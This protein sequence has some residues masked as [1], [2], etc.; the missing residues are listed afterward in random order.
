MVDLNKDLVVEPEVEEAGGVLRMQPLNPVPKSPVQVGTKVGVAVEHPDDPYEQEEKSWGD[1]LFDAY[2]HLDYARQLK[3]LSG[4]MQIRRRVPYIYRQGYYENGQW[5]DKEGRKLPPPPEEFIEGVHESLPVEVG[6]FLLGDYLGDP[7]KVMSEIATGD[8][9]QI[10][11]N[12]QGMLN[13]AATSIFWVGPAGRKTFEAGKWAL[14]KAIEKGMAP[15][16]FIYRKAMQLIPDVLKPSHILEGVWERIIVPPFK[17]RFIPTTEGMK[18][19]AEIMQPA[20]ERLEKVPLPGGKG[21][22]ASPFRNA[23]AQKALVT[24]L[25]EDIGREIES[26]PPKLRFEAFK[27]LR[28]LPAAPEGEK[29]V[30]MMHEG[31]KKVGT[32]KTFRDSY[33]DALRKQLQKPR[34]LSTEDSKLLDMPNVEKVLNIIDDQMQGKQDVKVI[35]KALKEV[36]EDPV[37]PTDLRALAM[38]L[39]NLPYSTVEAVGAASRKAAKSFILAGLKRSG[40]VKAAIPEGENKADWMLSRIP[41]IEGSWVPKDVELELRA[42]RDVPKIA[43]RSWG[44]YFMTPWKVSK[45]I[46]SPATHIRNTVSNVILNDIGGLPFYRVDYYK[47]A[48]KELMHDGKYWRQW[49][50][51]TG[52]GG[53]FSLNELQQLQGGLKYGANMID[54]ALAWFDKKTAVPKEMYNAEEQLAKVA[55]FMWNIER[56][57]MTPQEAALDAM[58]WTFNYAEVTRFTANVRGS[59]APFYTWTSKVLPLMAE[60]AVKHPWRLAKWWLFYQAM[61]EASLSS[62]KISDSEFDYIHKILPAYMQD[63]QFL[64]MPWRDDDGRLQF[65]NL[66]YMIP[67]FGDWAD[68]TTDPVGNFMGTPLIQIAG[69]LALNKTYSGAPIWLEEDFPSTKLMKA[70]GFI[71]RQ[72][73][74]NSIIMPGSLNWNKM[75]DSMQGRPGSLTWEQILANE[76]GFKIVPID[77][78]LAAKRKQV[79]DQIHR[80]E[81]GAEMKRELRRAR[82]ASEAKEI[83]QRYNR[84]RLKLERE[85]FD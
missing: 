68:I 65:L 82:N 39:Y 9:Y 40:V 17:Q 83:V 16:R 44:R 12:I 42:I 75:W 26:M 25:G 33:W 50:K 29:V 1:R 53:T 32:R 58:K 43:A 52:S 63:G 59:V 73:V 57:H 41:G 48:V 30:K 45:V 60:Q 78:A 19:V 70:F 76:A 77:P 24:K 74:P 61:Q 34:I 38:D 14:L 49:Q 7:G 20:I 8:P 3:E 37:M 85:R 35:Q 80:Q 11:D 36:I 46:L 81:I 21:T 13:D 5:Y 18:S 10:R 64:L 54:H 2:M 4:E 22:L 69:S 84:L 51:L 71:W 55:K 72:V 47:R 62:L 56:E 28:G 67:G 15:P 27:A 31:L 6:K 66:T 79:V 23:M